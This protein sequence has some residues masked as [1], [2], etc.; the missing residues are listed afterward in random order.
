MGKRDKKTIKYSKVAGRTIE[1]AIKY[2]ALEVSPSKSGE[3]TE[4][5]QRLRQ[6][7]SIKFQIREK[8]AYILPANKRH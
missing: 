2:F 5:K 1:E 7:G 4:N 8:I 6:I 3:A